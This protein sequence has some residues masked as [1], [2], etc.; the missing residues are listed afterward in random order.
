MNSAHGT[1]T[2]HNEECANCGQAIEM[3]LYWDDDQP[4]PVVVCGP[5]GEPIE[6]IVSD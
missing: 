5:C 1:V 2:C 6:D 3:T 4:G